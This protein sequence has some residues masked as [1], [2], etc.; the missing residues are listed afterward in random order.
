MTKVFV[1]AQLC[2]INFYA[3]TDSMLVCTTPAPV[4]PT[5]PNLA[6][7]VYAAVNVLVIGTD[8]AEYAQILGGNVLF[9]KHTHT[10]TLAN[11]I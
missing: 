2:P 11:C 7:A 1:G 9:I 8:R 10:C 5:A 3:S 6:V 4:L